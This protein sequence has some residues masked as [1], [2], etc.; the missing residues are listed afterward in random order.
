MEVQDIRRRHVQALIDQL[1]GSGVAPAR[2]VAV[3]DA[4]QTLYTYAIRRELV[5]F[6]PWSSSSSPERQRRAARPCPA[7][8]G[9]RVPARLDVGRA[10]PR[11][12]R[13]PSVDAAPRPTLGTGTTNGGSP[14]PARPGHRIPPT[15]TAT[16]LTSCRSRPS[17]PTPRLRP[18]HTAA[19]PP[20]AAAAYPQGYTAPTRRRMHP[21]TRPRLVH[22]AARPG[23]RTATS[24]AVH[25][26]CSAS[27]RGRQHWRPGGEL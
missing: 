23:C 9:R 3:T 4:L 15:R 11:P 5:G 14:Q 20:A 21:A 27:P 13:R 2:V 1:N 19:G 12:R 6:S 7:A 18:A 10:G 24:R 25:A 17:L 26:A 8:P 16:R 22:A